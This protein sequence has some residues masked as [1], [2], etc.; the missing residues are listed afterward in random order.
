MFKQRQ[1][2][3]RA[4]NVTDSPKTH[5]AVNPFQSPSSVKPL[6]SPP[7][8]WYW[9]QQRGRGPVVMFFI[10]AIMGG[11]VAAGTAAVGATAFSIVVEF[12]RIEH[13]VELALIA[14]MLGG[15]LAAIP[16]VPIGAI[17]G[18]VA[19]LTKPQVRRWLRLSAA[20]AFALIVSLIG[21]S[22]ALILVDRGFR[23][24]G[25]EIFTINAGLICGSISGALGGWY[26]IRLLSN[27]CWGRPPSRPA[28]ADSTRATVVESDGIDDQNERIYTGLAQGM[29]KFRVEIESHG[30][31]LKTRLAH[32]S[33][34]LTY[35]AAL[36]LWQNDAD[37]RN[38]FTAH[39]AAC[40]FTAF[41]WETP[42]VTADT[43]DRLFEFVLLDCPALAGP[44]DSTSFANQLGTA[45]PG[46]EVV[47]FA[48]LGGD[49]FLVVPC[50]TGP[51][52]AYGHLA[53]FVREAPA[54]QQHALWQTVAAELRARISQQ[55]L[56]LST[57]GLGVPWLHV[58][59]DTRPKYYGHAPYR[60]V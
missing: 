8:E 1:S 49:A 41:R 33:R 22:G 30:S 25:W 17:L 5:A 36:Y 26:F 50:A 38:F 10:G 54:P 24:P 16:G 11:V 13:S 60:T 48:N 44:A 37:F 7:A 58:R 18:L 9:E 56:W 51:E 28:A 32:G 29:E 15:V 4:I 14:S 2:F 59:I 53:A 45:Q 23:Y 27:I 6:K 35:K 46:E 20:G 12:P 57:A 34:P 47:A 43:L 39:L 42:P 52:S 55:P 19:G 40:P 31:V 3:A 21:V